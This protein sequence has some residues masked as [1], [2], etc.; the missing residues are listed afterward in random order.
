MSKSHLS[1]ALILFIIAAQPHV[2][3]ARQ[4]V[5]TSQ[6]NSRT[7]IGFSIK[8]TM[9]THNGLAEKLTG[10]ASITDQDELRAAQFVVPIASMKTGNNQRDCHL[11]E[12][13]GIEYVGSIFPKHHVCDD[14]NQLPATGANSLRHPNIVFNFQS[15]TKKPAVP[16]RVGELQTVLVS[17]TIQIHGVT[18]Q[19]SNLPVQLLMNKSSGKT[20]IRL[21]SKMVIVL[22]DFGII[23]KPFKVFVA[24]ISVAKQASV[25]LDIL[26][27]EK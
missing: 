21:I 2:A 24:S 5:P 18:R 19:I 4:F 14:N 7:G 3:Q 13:L 1:L 12:A 17:G 8:Y 26:L 16:L 23:V 25:S 10:S 11:R 9:G 27:I 22:S 15:Y 6:E 20:T